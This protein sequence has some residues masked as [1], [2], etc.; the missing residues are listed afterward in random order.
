MVCIN[1]LMKQVRLRE[2]SPSRGNFRDEEGKYPV[3]VRR[4]SGEER[5]VD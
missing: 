1:R 3:H 2:I 5:G 4:G